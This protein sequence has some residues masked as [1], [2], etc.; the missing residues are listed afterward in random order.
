MVG[1]VCT[2]GWWESS[3]LLNL[4]SVLGVVYEYGYGVQVGLLVAFPADSRQP[5]AWLRKAGNCDP[6]GTLSNVQELFS[7]HCL[8]KNTRL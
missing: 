4:A 3:W 8:H 6:A 7:T 2:C 5:P 1:E